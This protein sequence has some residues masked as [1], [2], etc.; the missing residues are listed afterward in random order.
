MNGFVAANGTFQI[1]VINS[2]SFS[3]RGTANN[4]G[5][6]TGGSFTVSG[7]SGASWALTNSVTSYSEAVNAPIVITT[8]STTGLKTGEAVTI[9]GSTL[10]TANGTFTITVINGTSFSLNGT[11]TATAVPSTA[12]TGTWAL[13][14]DL[15]AVPS[16]PVTVDGTP[17]GVTLL[18]ANQ[19]GHLDLVTAN[20]NGQDFSLLQGNGDGTFQ[21]AVNT[22]LI[23]AVQQSVAVGDLNGDGIADLVVVNYNGSTNNTSVLVYQGLA[24]GGYA[25]PVSISPSF[26][27]Q[28]MR[29]IVSVALGDVNNDGH[30]DILLLDQVDSTV[31]ILKN[32]LTT[33]GATINASSFTALAPVAVG[34]TPDQ[35]VVG[36][37]NGDHNLDIAVAHAGG[38]GNKGVSV[39]LGNG[40]GTFGPVV[41]YAKGLTVQT[42]AAAD[43]NKDGNLDLV[44]GKNNNGQGGSV[45]LLQGKGDGTFT[46]TG[47]YN[48][49]LANV[50][51]LAVADFNSDGYADV[52]VSSSSTNATSGG[53]AV[54]LNQAGAGFGTPI[55]TSP[56]PGTGLNDVVVSDINQDGVPDLVVST[57]A[58]GKITNDNVF[59]L[60]GNGDGTFQKATPYLA[61]SVGSTAA[62][63]T[64]ALT[65]SPLIEITSFNTNGS[66][67]TTNLIVN[68]AFE[69][70]DLAGQQGNLL[71]WQTYY[72]STPSGGSNG[73]WLPQSGTTSPL[74]GTT[75]PAPSGNYR[76]MLDEANQVPYD[77]A[78][79]FTTNPNL[80]SSYAGTQVL[81]Q[82]IAVP[83]AVTSLTASFSLYIDN[84]GSTYT[85]STSG[86][87]DPS[88]N[89]SLDY[90]TTAANQQV[91]VDL[92][93][94]L[95]GT[96]TGATNG[97]PII[98]TTNSTAGLVSNYT[99]IQVSGVNGDTNANGIWTVTVIDGTHF[100][101][102]GSN[103]IIGGTNF[104]YAGGGTWS[105]PTLGVTANAGLLENLFITTPKTATTLSQNV[106]LKL[107]GAIT[108][109]TNAG[110]IVITSA[111][112]GLVSGETIYV[113][114]VQG[115]GAANGTWVITV[116]DAS[117]FSL[118]G[119]NG[120]ITG[121]NTAYTGGGTWSILPLSQ[122]IGQTL[123]FRVAAADNQGQILV[124]IDNVS[125]TATY[126]DTTLPTL[127]G[128]AMRNPGILGGI[129]GTT[130][131]TDD[132]TLVGTVSANGGLNNIAFVAFSPNNDGFGGNDVLKTTQIDPTGKFTFTLPNPQPGLNTIGVE[133]VD[134]AG[135]V[136]TQTL[137][138]FML[139][140]GNV[141]NWQAVGPQSISTAGQ[142]VNYATVSGTITATVQDMS[143]PTGN[144]FFI[145]SAN[146][147]VWK[148]TD[149]GA[150]WTPLTDY[151]T[152]ASG[153][154]VAVPVGGLAQSRSNPNILYAGTG[155][156]ND[157]PNSQ[158][159]IG[160]LKSVDDG[161]TWTVA[162]NSGTVLAGARVTNVVI[163][164]NNSN[165]VYVSVASGG[166]S[167]PGVYKS[168]DGGLTWAN[169]LVQSQMLLA[170]GGTVASGDALASVTS[171]V[172][173]PFNSSRLL[174]GLGNIG[175]TATASDTAGLWISANSG[176]TWRQIVGG[177]LAI[178]QGV[179]NDTL[180]TGVGLGRVTVAIGD[181][182]VASV[183]AESTIYVLISTPPTSF[184]TPNLNYGTDYKLPTVIPNNPY[185]GLYK[186][187][188]NG[189]D[190][191]R[192][193]LEQDVGTGIPYTANG[194]LF[195]G[196]D[197]FG[198]NGANTG[199]LAVDPNDPNVVYVGGS[200]VG[201]G[202]LNHELIRVDTGNMLDYTKTARPQREYHH[203]QQR[204]RCRQGRQVRGA[205]IL[206]P[207]RHDQRHYLSEHRPLCERRGVL[208]R[209]QPGRQRQDRAF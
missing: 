198:S 175:L 7:V 71:G 94:T 191:T 204:R 100:S 47:T 72:E 25:S 101:L 62:P 90:T 11:T 122:L 189:N 83:S 54:L 115:N 93:N 156:G 171:L 102:N 188:D 85:G 152:T 150:D 80:A 57:L 45:V 197:L 153:T 192:V 163:D 203:S 200:S 30:P 118:I 165:I 172:I 111:N 10:A 199:A 44:A 123:T 109:A 56:V 9:T 114:G 81:Y 26:G 107:I 142:N 135:N 79:P 125:V 117:H 121:G 86:Y 84:S 97:S 3:L 24:T 55:L 41:E 66:L 195:T 147:G 58:N 166:I 103:G 99:Q 154:P 50:N 88:T 49:G 137:T 40:N 33:A 34:K 27:G 148:T 141:E 31:G 162:G 23:S 182:S 106:S 160:V 76:A 96:I 73:A 119:S 202:G 178:S 113:N 131:Y 206:L 170:A 28:Q 130:P 146:G 35:L 205:E 129:N 21:T 104:A 61:G 48:T 126:S 20:Q 190:W 18:D 144:S 14:V 39:L 185:Q 59:V 168:T 36:D 89:P 196:I 17:T 6:G 68:G 194:T 29:T 127:T 124:G 116:I 187:S 145:A 78:N 132:P 161:K 208:V 37:F 134:K 74:S 139:T 177:D 12:D 209:S 128:L 13:T 1:T 149:N 133:V 110:P 65:P 70:R 155:V 151:V 67:V 16:T 52:V 38:F 169:V 87:T 174:A 184:T 63:T 77:T 180:P 173:D 183:A 164:A 64:I 176:G 140:T 60:I 92:L 5:S 136:T 75:V 95:S 32:N 201:G 98:I 157:N 108:G 158:V 46:V 207:R 2:T 143:D 138:F 43:F 105:L 19:D 193:A 181:T 15:V 22:A 4:A 186:S 82:N 120:A 179:P 69:A 167:G 91:R 42:I 51:A 112:N 159:G 8:P 53:V